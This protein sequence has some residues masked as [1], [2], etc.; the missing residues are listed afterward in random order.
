MLIDKYRGYTVYRIDG[1]DN[2]PS[3]ELSLNYRAQTHGPKVWALS[4][5]HV[6]VSREFFFRLWNVRLRPDILFAY[7]VPQL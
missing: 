6:P 1:G 4:R 2:M 5:H 3:T 7:Y